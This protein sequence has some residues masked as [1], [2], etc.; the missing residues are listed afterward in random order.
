MYIAN[1]TSGGLLLNESRAVA[2]L[3]LSGVPADKLSDT[4]L[5]GNVLQKRTPSSAKRILN[6]LMLRLKDLDAPYL[7]FLLS[8]G[9][10]EASLFLLAVCCE[11]HRILGDFLIYIKRDCIDQYRTAISHEDWNHYFARCI[12]AEP[13]IDSWTEATRKKLRSTMFTMLA[14][15]GVIEK[16]SGKLLPLY[17]SSALTDYLASPGHEN[18]RAI[19]E[20]LLA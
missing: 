16:K 19:L 13:E 14:N 5:T 8:A 15:A 12:N 7:E 17:F 10:A 18:T 9:S 11:K 20:G 1:F 2:R 6:L 4:V 3:L